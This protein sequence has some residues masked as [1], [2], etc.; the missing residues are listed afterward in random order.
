MKR[1]GPCALQYLHMSCAYDEDHAEYVHLHS[2]HIRHVCARARDAHATSMGADWL[3]AEA[4]C[5]QN[6]W[7]H[8]DSAFPCAAEAYEQ[9]ALGEPGPG[10]TC[11][12]EESYC[13]PCGA[14]MAGPSVSLTF[15]YDYFDVVVL[16]SDYEV[17]MPL[18]LSG[19]LCSGDRLTACMLQ[20]M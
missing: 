10:P 8:A 19:D 1:W 3:G 20:S 15:A 2:G 13:A 7:Q 11:R 4:S 12:L 9:N 16:Q 6:A 5:A 18:N 17:L 14:A